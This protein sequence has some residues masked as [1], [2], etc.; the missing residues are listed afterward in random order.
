MTRARVI[1]CARR[2][3][4]D[5]SGA[6]MVEFAIVLALFLL[7]FFALIDFGRL[8]FDSV[9]AQ[10]AT[11][12]A[13]RI[14]VVRPPVCAD[15]PTTNARANSESTENF[16]TQ[17]RE[18]NGLCAAPGPF[19]CTLDD[20]AEGTQ[21]RGT[22]DEIWRRVG[23]LLPGNATRADIRVTYES[24]PELGFLG[25]PYIPIVSVEIV[26]LDFQF[27][28]PLGGLAGLAGAANAG[29]LGSPLGFPSMRA[30]LPAEDLNHGGG[31]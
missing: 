9:M 24:D 18:V 30:S 4:D 21:A 27:V 19:V 8:G 31:Q 3:R 11:H 10:K 26:D 25:G 28:T 14:A 29:D 15:V 23:G 22:A 12:N 20:P 13:A 16:G 1:W 17:C 7:I 5:E 6:T 2:L